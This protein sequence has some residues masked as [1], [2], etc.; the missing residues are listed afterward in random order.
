MIIKAENFLTL[1]RLALE[2]GWGYIMGSYGG[3]WTAKA[4][5]ATSDSMAK[6]YGA[7][8]IGDRVAD[9]SGLGYWAFTALGG[10]MYHGSNTM[11]NNYVYD[12]AE[13]KNGVRTD[14]KEIW[15]GDPVFRKK[16]E[17]GKVNRHH[18]GYYMGNGIVIEARGTQYGVVSNLNGG[19]GRGL[20]D[21]HETAHWTGMQYPKEGGQEM[22]YQTVKRGDEG[23]DVKALQALLNGWGY[24]LTVDGKFGAKTEAAVAQFQAKIGLPTTGICGPETWEALTQEPLEQVTVQLDRKAAT[25]LYDAL[26]AAGIR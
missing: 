10:Q 5:A 6:K 22:S 3:F 18:V 24:N 26:K 19:K 11:W 9:C 25:A 23:A 4:Q 16:T 17:N 21:W 14:G 1:I 8:W 2:E 20:K 12:R 7:K 13:L 15:P